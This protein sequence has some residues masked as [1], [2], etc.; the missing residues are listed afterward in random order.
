MNNTIL[1]L[2]NDARSFVPKEA[3]KFFPHELDGYVF[4]VEK[5]TGVEVWNH[6]YPDDHPWKERAEK[7]HFIDEVEREVAENIIHA[8]TMWN[9]KAEKI[10]EAK[11][12]ESEKEL[13]ATETWLLSLPKSI[14]GFTRCGSMLEDQ[15]GNV[16]ADL[17]DSRLRFKTVE[18]LE[19]DFNEFFIE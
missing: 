11:Q 4:F 10:A 19:A 12:Q 15:Y 5:I 1:V 3:L 6:I 17:T 13:Q 16:I 2:R 8:V 7:N 18:Q 9:A 14:A